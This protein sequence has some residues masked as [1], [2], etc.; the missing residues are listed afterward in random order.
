M[1]RQPEETGGNVHE[2]CGAGDGRHNSADLHAEECRRVPTRGLDMCGEHAECPTDD[3]TD[4]PG[5]AERRCPA[6]PTG[7][8]RTATSSAVIAAVVGTSGLT[9]SAINAR[10]IEPIKRPAKRTTGPIA[11]QLLVTTTIAATSTRAP[12]T[13]AT[14]AAAARTL[15]RD[16]VRGFPVF[17]WSVAVAVAVAVAAVAGAARAWMMAKSCTNRARIASVWL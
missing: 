8:A 5:L 12:P 10:P 1:R 6:T 13:P 7:T 11:S 4:R 3:Q 2:R 14:Q 17:R 9:R 15:A 16:T